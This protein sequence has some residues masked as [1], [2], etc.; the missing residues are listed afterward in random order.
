MDLGHYSV[1]SGV[2]HLGFAGTQTGYNFATCFNFTLLIVVF[3]YLKTLFS[4][5]SNMEV[6]VVDFKAVCYTTLFLENQNK[7]LYRKVM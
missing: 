2:K 5:V 6:V 4:C 7:P 3:L 1:E